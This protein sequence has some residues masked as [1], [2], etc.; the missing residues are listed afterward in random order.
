MAKAAIL[1]LE[2]LT[3]REVV[4]LKFGSGDASRAERYELVNAEE[5]SLIQ[6][7]RLGRHVQRISE[8]ST[9][10]LTEEGAVEM[11]RILD[12]TLRM[13]LL[14]PDEVHAKLTDMQR[15]RIF[16]AF[17]QLKGRRT[18]ASPEGEVAAAGPSTGES[19]SRG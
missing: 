15:A 3:E 6:E 7:N 19:G 5:L 13:V 10:T 2:A 17:S 14:A 9:G 11:A 8:L 1:E 16:Q 4:I 18:P 12:E